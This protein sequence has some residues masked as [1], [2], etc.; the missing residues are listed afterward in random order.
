M[1]KYFENLPNFR[2]IGGHKARGGRTVATGRVYRSAELVDISPNDYDCLTEEIGLASVIDLR[3]DLER[4]RQG[5]GPLSKAKIQHYHVNLI[6]DGGD[7]AADAVR[8]KNMT[9]MGDFYLS[10]I[11]KKEFARLVIKALE[12][13]ADAKNHP[14]VFHCAV[15]KDRTGLVAVFLLSTLGVSDTDI[16]ADYAKSAPYT[17]G[18]YERLNSSPETTAF[19]NLFPRYF[20]DAD[21]ASMAK[22]LSSLKNEYGSAEAYL[23]VNGADEILVKRLETALLV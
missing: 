18:I 15:G 9:D 7:R 21:P 10:T 12:I 5:I 19:A 17:N 22:L 6:N 8:Y 16:V 1:E 4:K 2:D 20:W 11:R 3:S 23:K 14:L 13:I